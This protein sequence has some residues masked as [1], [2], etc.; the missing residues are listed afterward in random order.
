MKLAFST[1]E[2]DLDRTVKLYV[3]Y[4][5]RSHP[6]IIAQWKTE[7]NNIVLQ[8]KLVNSDQQKAIEIKYTDGSYYVFYVGAKYEEL[9]GEITKYTPMLDVAYSTKK[10]TR[11]QPLSFVPIVRSQGYILVQHQYDGDSQRAYPSKLTLKDLAVITSDRKHS[12]E[13]SVSLENNELK[14]NGHLI[15]GRTNIEMNGYV[16][17]HFPTYTIGGTINM[18]RSEPDND[19]DDYAPNSKFM[20]FLYKLKTLNIFT[21]QQLRIKSPYALVTD[22]KIQWDNGDFK[23][24][25]DM[26]FEDDAFTMYGKISTFNFFDLILNGEKF[27]SINKFYLQ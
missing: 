17:G 4:D 2:A 20:D 26:H 16:G 24:S 10:G 22:N 13:G 27:Y 7:S 23:M 21:A 9:D 6:K 5:T 18:I 3:T 15:T 12:L 1:P 14:G 25:G 19:S 11:D 8:S